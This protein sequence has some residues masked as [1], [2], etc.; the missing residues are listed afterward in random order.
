VSW[1]TLGAAAEMDPTKRPA[2]V[3]DNG[4]GYT[5]VRGNVPWKRQGV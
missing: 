2:V 1:N 4:T 5:K 3:I